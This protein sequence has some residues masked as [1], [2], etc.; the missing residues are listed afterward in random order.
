MSFINQIYQSFW[1]QL[2]WLLAAIVVGALL[3]NFRRQVLK[4]FRHFRALM[5]NTPAR[6]SAT[7]VSKYRDPPKSWLSKEVFDTL[8]A[9][10]RTDK[11]RKLSSSEK[12]I[13]IFSEKLGMPLTISLEEEPDIA[14]VSDEK[15]IGYKVTIELEAELRIGLRS[16]S[17]FQYF[18][19]TILAHYSL[20]RFPRRVL[21]IRLS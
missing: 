8:S 17:E 19:M 5:L 11:L 7:Y 4:R 9:R 3:T 13:G 20:K 18:V 6:V 2:F 21:K 10:L 1:F 14:N 12:S 16:V 15:V